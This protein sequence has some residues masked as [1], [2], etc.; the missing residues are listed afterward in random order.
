MTT[1]SVFF[2]VSK[3]IEEVKKMK[4]IEQVRILKVQREHI[5]PTE[6]SKDRLTMVRA[7]SNN[8]N[9]AIE[10]ARKGSNALRINVKLTNE[11]K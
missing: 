11:E 6:C 3:N 2:R 5:R 9:E 1:Y 7:V 4:G 10:L 8:M